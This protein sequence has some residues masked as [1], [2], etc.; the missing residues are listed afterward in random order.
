MNLFLQQLITARAEM[1]EYK[2]RVEQEKVSLQREK[3]TI[4]ENNTQKSDQEVNEAGSVRDRQVCT[5]FYPPF[6]ANI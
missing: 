3:Q 6:S 5:I 2:K 1:G 4:E